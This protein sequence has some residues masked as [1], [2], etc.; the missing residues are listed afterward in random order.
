MA[1]GEHPGVSMHE[2]CHHLQVRMKPMQSLFK[3]LH[4]RLTV[5]EKRGRIYRD[6]SPG[7]VG[8]LDKYINPYMGREYA[9]YYGEPY[10]L[11]AMAYQYMFFD[12]RRMI[13]GKWNDRS[14]IGNLARDNPDVFRLALGLLFR[15]GP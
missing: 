15:Y 13:G 8:R 6:H 9:E 1:G 14:Q 7:E 5:G 12:E 11:M 3:K 10:E 4:K 2:F